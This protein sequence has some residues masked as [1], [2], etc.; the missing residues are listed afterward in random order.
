MSR[1]NDDIIVRD[2]AK[3]LN[4]YSS[5]LLQAFYNE[6]IVYHFMSHIDRRDT[7]Q[8]LSTILIAR[9]TPAQKPRGFANKIF[10]ELFIKDLTTTPVIILL[11]KFQL[12]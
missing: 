11:I 5:T 4:K 10:I 3:L 1:E 12:Q 6:T 2:F 9:S 8:G 7:F